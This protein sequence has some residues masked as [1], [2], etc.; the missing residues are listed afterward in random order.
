[1]EI[2]KF[3]TYEFGVT[4]TSPATLEKDLVN[5]NYKMDEENP[6]AS[7]LSFEMHGKHVDLP[8]ELVA[9]IGKAMKEINPFAFAFEE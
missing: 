2:K 5:V 1:M 7:V 9:E 3:T 8:A 6:A 4:Y